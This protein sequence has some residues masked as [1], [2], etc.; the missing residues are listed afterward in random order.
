MSS[1]NLFKYLL[2]ATNLFVSALVSGKELPSVLT[3][4]G[5]YRIY[6]EKAL[7]LLNLDAEIEVLAKGFEWAE[8]P[9]WD[10]HNN[11][12]LFADIPNNVIHAYSDQSGLTTFLSPSGR[13]NGMLI[14]ESGKLVMM[15]T[16]ARAVSQLTTALNDTQHNVKP[17]VSHYRGKRLNSPNDVALHKNG[18]LFFTDPPYGL[19]KRMEDP[20]KELDFQGVYRLNVDGSLDVLDKTLTYPNGIAISPKQDKLYV[21]VSDKSAPAWYQYSL[22]DEG[23]VVNKS[24]LFKPTFLGIEHGVPDGL[25]VHSSGVVFATGPGGIWILAEDGRLLAQVAMKGFT[26]NIAF[27]DSESAI[28]LTAHN[29]LRRLKLK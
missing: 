20:A 23:N 19:P 11:R 25:K 13:S 3:A 26:A 18:S 22:D 17:L 1:K 10:S 27:D 16:E 15:Q 8:G 5:N 29:E 6:D 12:L 28:Y 9:V 7:T 2:L 4:I 14:N 21:S 24:L